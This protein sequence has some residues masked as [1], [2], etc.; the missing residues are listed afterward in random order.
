M[1]FRSLAAPEQT[2]RAV[3]AESRRRWEQHF[4]AQAGRRHLRFLLTDILPVAL[5]EQA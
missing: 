4:S 2:R 1:L 3:A 5:K